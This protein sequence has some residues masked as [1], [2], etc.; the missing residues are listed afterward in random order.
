[1]YISEIPIT[2]AWDMKYESQF[3]AVDDFDGLRAAIESNDDLNI[4][5]TD[6]T[7][8]TALQQAAFRGN[9]AMCRY[10]LDKG[11]DVNSDKHENQ[12]T[13]LMFGALSGTTYSIVT[14]WL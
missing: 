4:N 11:A 7:G 1:M 14:R 12:Y 5:T 2:D 13:T 10:L 3:F 8:M 9:A 6:Q